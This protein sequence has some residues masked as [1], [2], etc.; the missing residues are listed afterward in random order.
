MKPT[1]KPAEV[2]QS[3]VKHGEFWFGSLT[4]TP[5]RT[6]AGKSPGKVLG[7]AGGKNIVL[8][9]IPEQG[10]SVQL[11]GPARTWIQR[12]TT[13]VTTH[14]HWRSHCAFHSPDADS[15]S[16]CVNSSSTLHRQHPPLQKVMQP[17]EISPG[18]GKS[19]VDAERGMKWGW[20]ATR[21]HCHLQ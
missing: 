7:V 11:Q 13:D 17:L 12:K 10:W 3:P 15:A 19:S 5:G 14:G 20:G 16:A 6:R 8:W 21:K 1:G 2:K 4:H 18:R 9:V